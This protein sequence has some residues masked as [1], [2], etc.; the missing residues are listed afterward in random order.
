MPAPDYGVMRSTNAGATWERIGY[1]P[2]GLITNR[3]M[4]AASWD[5]FGLVGI[6]TGG[7]GFVYGKPL[8]A[9]GK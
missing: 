6:A 2:A 7:Q 8:A 4:M 3:G 1:W 5:I 9:A